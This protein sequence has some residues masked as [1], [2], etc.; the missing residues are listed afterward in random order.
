M[1]PRILRRLILTLNQVRALNAISRAK[2]LPPRFREEGTSSFV[3]STNGIHHELS[4]TNVVDRHYRR[5]MRELEENGNFTATNVPTSVFREPDTTQPN[6][7]SSSSSSESEIDQQQ[8]PD[9]AAD[10]GDEGEGDSSSDETDVASSTTSSSSSSDDIETRYYTNPYI[11]FII[12][13]MNNVLS[14]D[15]YNNKKDILRLL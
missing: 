4:R 8:Q 13:N 11:L 1:P 15:V 12:Y 7:E 2:N 3:V 9:D 6:A 10:D 5:L 14:I